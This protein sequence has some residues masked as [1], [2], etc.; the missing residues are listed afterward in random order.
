MADSVSVA[1][2]SGNARPWRAR[3]YLGDRLVALSGFCSTAERAREAAIAAYERL[4]A[5]GAE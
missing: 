1:A 3:V 2:Y 5:D 4:N